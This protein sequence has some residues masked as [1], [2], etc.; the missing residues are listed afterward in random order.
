MTI[1]RG[2]GGAFACFAAAFF[3]HIVGGALD[4]DWLFAAAVALIFVTGAGF[5]VIALALARPPLWRQRMALLI[6]GSAAGVAL[7]GAALWAANGR[8]LA[9]WEAPAAAALV[10]L[11]S[12]AGLLA[13]MW[14]HGRESLAL[15]PPAAAMRSRRQT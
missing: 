14:L 13:W 6:A 7:T 5:P 10:A 12:G 2:L 9:W 3:L 1:L 15:R 11:T 4:Q 8:S